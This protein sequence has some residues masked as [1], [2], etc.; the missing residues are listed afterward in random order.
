MVYW[1]VSVMGYEKNPSNGWIFDRKQAWLR[2][3][4]EQTANDWIDVT[5]DTGETKLWQ[6]TPFLPDEFTLY[7]VSGC[8]EEEGHGITQ[9]RVIHSKDRDVRRIVK[10]SSDR[11]QKISNALIPQVDFGPWQELD[12]ARMG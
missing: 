5:R 4:E 12:P 10:R 1:L 8:A 2:F 3:N 11:Y 7:R 6:L 9:A